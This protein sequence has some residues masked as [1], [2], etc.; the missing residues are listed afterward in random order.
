MSPDAKHAAEVAALGEGDLPAPQHAALRRIAALMAAGAPAHELF[1]VVLREIMDVLALSRGWLFRYEAGPAMSVLASVNYPPF[2]V[3]SRWPL[4][5]P[6]VAA[7]IRDTGRPAR[8]DDYSGLGGTIAGRVREVGVRSVCGVPIFVDGGIWGGI[9]VSPEDNQLLPTDTTERLAAFTELVAWVI[10]SAATRDRLATLADHQTSLRRVATLVAEEAPAAELFAAVTVEAT[11]VLGVP[12]MIVSRYDSGA[13]SVVVAS[14][15]ARRFTVGSRWALDEPGVA[16][17]VYATGRPARIDDYSGLSGRPA[18]GVRDSG[19]GSVVGV[20]IMVEGR[21]WGVGCASTRATEA[22][23]AGIEDRLRDFTDL[24]G[25]AIASAESRQRPRRLAEEQAALRRVATLVAEGAAPAAVFSAVAREVARILDVAAVTVVRFESNETSV[26]VASHND[27]GFPVGSRWPLDGPSLHAMVFQSGLPARV[28]D[29]E[30]L[31]GP[32]AAAA[33]ASGVRSGIAVPITVDGRVWGMIAVGLR[34]PRATLPAHAGMLSSRLVLSAASAQ[35]IEQRLAAFTELVA[36]AIS[37]AQVHDDLRS[38]A[39]EQAALRRV[40][41]LVARG[42]P[43]DAL[44]TAVCDEVQALA[45]TD[46]CVVVR[47]EVDGMV[48]VM[49]T[50]AARHPVGARLELDPDYV[51]G[52]VYRTGR[53]ARFDTDDPAATGMP[54][55]VRAE[56]IRC[57]L[58]SPI[59]VEGG[60]WGAITTASRERPVPAGMERRLADFTELVATAISNLQARAELAASRAR[61]AAA[62]DDERRRVVRDLHDGAQQR[63]V[64]TVVT[65]KL[66]QQALARDAADGPLLVQEALGNAEQATAEVREL[67]HG[68]LPSVL[69]QGG[70]RAG[71]DAL[72]A[73]APVPVAIDVSVERLPAPVEASAYFVVAEALTNVAKHSSAE[74]AEV[75]ARIEDGM[76]RVEVR[77]DGVGGASPD[78]SGLVGLADRVAVLDGRLE[79]DSPP[80]AGTRLTAAIP[81]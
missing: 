12:A 22:L 2:P 1:G 35:E 46:A 17:R 47:F 30:G 33:R 62:A 24:V 41:T 32:V 53:P 43:S 77:D 49:G 7:T 18:A 68:I 66:A 48:T 65:L 80:G 81:L 11:R 51:V 67:A 21:I 45:G 64:H 61:I 56:G 29:H 34:P 78:G 3:G 13:E 57:G 70:L 50:N 52:E 4:D 25:I 27:A 5:G 36:T 54:G 59:V 19:L 72:G 73:R 20:P 16:A 31:P 39:D 58:A 10:S 63:L 9:G 38:L 6:S 60:L 8:L 79:V 76:L 74:H 55:L 15:N 28:D 37:K 75:V 26:V 69:T 23:P 71:I 44:F 42:V 14:R 40:A